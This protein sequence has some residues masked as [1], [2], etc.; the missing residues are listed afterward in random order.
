M[1]QWW[2]TLG[3]TRSCYQG[4]QSPSHSLPPISGSPQAC[5]PPPVT[6][7]SKSF[8]FI[9]PHLRLL[10]ISLLFPHSFQ[11]FLFVFFLYLKFLA[12]IFFLLSF[13][14]FFE[15][16]DK[17]LTYIMNHTKLRVNLEILYIYILCSVCRSAC[18]MEGTIT[19]SSFCLTKT[20]N[21]FILLHFKS[22]RQFHAV[23]DGL[24]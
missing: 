13:A 18:F 2:T 9:T 23:F 5:L 6:K 1:K 3:S 15:F 16:S 10:Y 11:T 12:D 19:L 8:T 24:L 7:I 20:S 14:K 4:Y 21:S 22:Q 17:K